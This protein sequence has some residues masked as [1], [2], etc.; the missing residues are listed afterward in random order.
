MIARHLAIIIWSVDIRSVDIR[1]LDIKSVDI[2]S[3]DIWSPELVVVPEVES[4]HVV[5]VLLGQLGLCVE[6]DVALLLDGVVLHPLL[7]GHAIESRNL[8]VAV[9][10][11]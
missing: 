10:T 7:A 6:R 9:R 11:I 5:E 2:T 8:A 3:V 1:S 4:E